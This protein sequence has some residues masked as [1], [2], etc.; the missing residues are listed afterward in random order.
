MWS[1]YGKALVALAFL[2]WTTVAPQLTGDGKIDLLEGVAIA[3]AAANGLLVYIVP[4]N[5]QWEAGKT[6]INAVLAAL[7]AVPTVIAD[8]IQPDDWTVIIGAAL[9]ILI[10]WVAPTISMAR[11]PQ[12]VQVDAGFTA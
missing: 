5:P 7:T 1:K 12:P 2:V 4:L 10:G 6:I 11:T 3:T 9:T 8:G